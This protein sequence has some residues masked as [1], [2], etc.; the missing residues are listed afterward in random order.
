MNSKKKFVVL[1]WLQGFNKGS[2][3]WTLNTNNNIGY[4][5]GNPLHKEVLFTDDSSEAI[6]ECNKN[7]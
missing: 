6:T 5:D 7:R 2:K 3:F 4:V 1:E